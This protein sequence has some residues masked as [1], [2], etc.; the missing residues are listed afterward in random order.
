MRRYN[1][2][3]MEREVLFVEAPGFLWR[4]GLQVGVDE[5]EV[6][7]AAVRMLNKMTA[8]SEVEREV[9]IIVETDFPCDTIDEWSVVRDL[10][11][12]FTNL[13]HADHEEMIV[14]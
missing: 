4:S 2:T 11:G 9:V 12:R 3:I 6:N 5:I 1:D 7:D 10:S 14:L 8:E 13:I